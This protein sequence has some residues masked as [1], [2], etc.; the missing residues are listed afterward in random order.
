MTDADEQAREVARVVERIRPLLAGRPPEV[1]G[2]VVAD[3][4]SIFIAGHHPALR[5]EVMQQTV[6]CARE[7]INANEQILFEQHGGRPPG[8]EM[9]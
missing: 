6:D 5:H 9:Q 3:L 8:W 1:Q 2:G 4:L 7:L